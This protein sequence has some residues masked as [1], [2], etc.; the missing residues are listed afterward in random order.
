M[1][2]TLRC[3]FA[4]M[5][6]AGPA[7][8]QVDTVYVVRADTVQRAR[9]DEAGRWLYELDDVHVSTR[10]LRLTQRTTLVGKEAVQRALEEGG[11][12]LIRRGV[13]L[14]SDVTLD[15]FKRGDVEVVIDGERYPNSC[16]NRMD[17]PA[18]RVN[19]LEMEAVR[20]DKSSTEVGAG[21]GG[22]IAFQRA[23]PAEVWRVK[24]N[25]TYAGMNDQALDAAVALEG[26]RHRVT[27][28]LVQGQS[29]RD[30]RN[31]S[32]ADRYGYLDEV[33]YTLGEVG[34]QGAAG[35]WAYGA[36][37]SISRDIPFP[38]L[39]MDER[40]N[41]MWNA[42][43]SF[44][45]H[46]LYV[47]R[48]HHVM[49]NQLRASAAR[50]GMET[51]ATNLTVGL[52]GGF[53]EVYYRNW[54]T[55]NTMTMAAMGMDDGMGGGMGMQPMHQHLIPDLHLAAASVSHA[56]TRGPFSLS[57]CLG[58][59]RTAIGDEAR[60]GFYRALYP[61]AEQ[62]RWFMPVSLSASL[63]AMLTD[64]LLGGLTLDLASEA[65]VPEHLYL[66]L[67]RMQ[68]Q[69]SWTGNP[70]L[71]APKRA[72][73]RGLLGTGAVTGEAFT[74]LAADY[75]ALD[76][77]ARGADRYVTYA[78]VTALLSGVTLRA[79]GRYAS[80]QASYTFGENL[81]ADRPLAEIAPLQ[82]SATLRSPVMWG[83][84]T[85]VRGQAA[86]S[87]PRV[88]EVLGETR[89]PRWGRLDVGAAYALGPV[90][91]TADLENVTNALYYQHL[92]YARD[93]FASGLA[94]YEPGRTLR[95]GLR[96][97]Y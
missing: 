55:W 13:L 79:D 40:D 42:F 23:A 12:G 84:S 80:A 69:P 81:T 85:Y 4:L 47:N 66:G 36:A 20:I 8:A 35:A 14:A 88:D 58:L 22:Q 68:G 43:T 21:L 61:T 9:Y 63:Q 24:G 45:G 38:Y 65:P 54:D 90:E 39:R 92:S 10:R 96:M 41:T 70:T 94:I 3:L 73:L 82:V 71:A 44:R 19:P 15:G 49:D 87:Q 29:Y 32:F 31:Q 51:D 77:A 93:P 97:A 89:T 52:T 56:L 18:V 72:T 53:Y 59:T 30:A 26:R 67:K 62:T 86:A 46:K 48:T 5:I 64:R 28:R 16:P 95:L 37:L 91:V 1:K 25:M 11:V 6:A 2:T 17:P 78:N 34:L 33:A 27:G 74:T 57:G 7:V 83:I 60:L 76:Q 50:M 75:V